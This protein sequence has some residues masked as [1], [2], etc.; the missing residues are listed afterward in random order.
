M[1]KYEEAMAHIRVT[2]AM[3]A[4]V[5]RRV[6]Q[7]AARRTAWRRAAALA[8]CLAVAVLGALVLPSV[9]QPADDVGGVLAPG[10]TQ[11]ASAEELSRLAGFQAPELEV[12]PFVP[13]Q[14][15]DLAG[16]VSL[17][18]EEM[19]G[20][21]IAGRKRPDRLPH[22]G[23]VLP[24]LRH[25]L[26]CQLVRPAA[27]VVPQAVLAQIGRHPQQPCLFM[28]RALQVGGGPQELEQ[29][30]LQDL[31]GVLDAVEIGVGQ[32]E[33]AVPEVVQ[34]PLRL[35]VDRLTAVCAPGAGAFPPCCR[36][37]PPDRQ[38]PQHPREQKGPQAGPGYQT[39][40]QTGSPPFLRGGGQLRPA[41]PEVFC[42]LT[43]SAGSARPC[44]RRRGAYPR[45]R[46]RRIRRPS[47]QPGRSGHPRPAWS[48]SGPPRPSPA[49]G[50][51][52]CSRR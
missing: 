42:R 28:G 25:Q 41:S 6:R 1:R 18:I 20:L 43:G 4:R 7:S 45:R 44:P 35:A 13:Q 30:V 39:A 37:C 24:L 38:T 8:A 31:L 2:P 19:E 15:G 33:D 23:E 48:R 21:P 27:R 50:H 32:P 14:P 47:R 51:R 34:Q 36:R 40:H 17:L 52:R 12:L 46:N 49:P 22:E 16:G 9:R 29:G 3:R 11:A 10:P 5:L 26:L